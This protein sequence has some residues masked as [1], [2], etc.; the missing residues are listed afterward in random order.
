LQAG[1]HYTGKPHEEVFIAQLSTADY[2]T[3]PLHLRYGS[4]NACPHPSE[5]AMLAKYWGEHYGA[6]IAAV[7][8]DTV[9]YTVENPPK[10]AAEGAVLAREQYIYC[11]D[12]VDQGVGSVMTLAEAL[13][14]STRWY[15]WWD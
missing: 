6:K 9:E 7:T 5:H 2:W 11:G 13:R 4:W 1:F 8:S 12:I 14:G 10:T 3:V 15:F